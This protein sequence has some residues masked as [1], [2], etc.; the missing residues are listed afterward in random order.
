MV[1]NFFLYK[2]VKNIYFWK[3]GEGE[4]SK[5]C[6]YKK[7]FWK[8]KNKQK[9]KELNLFNFLFFCQINFFCLKDNDN[10]DDSDDDN[11]DDDNDDDDGDNNADDSN[12]DHLEK[13]K[14][15]PH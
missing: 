10:G 14:I 13:Y 2:N 3:G 12:K 8:K 15:T 11:D 4:V 9:K 7:K 1:C 6:K 5:I